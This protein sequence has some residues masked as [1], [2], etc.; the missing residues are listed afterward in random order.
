MKI[1]IANYGSADMRKYMKYNG[2]N[3][4]K[5]FQGVVQHTY[6]PKSIKYFPTTQQSVIQSLRQSIRESSVR[7]PFLLRKSTVRNGNKY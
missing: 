5:E 6:Q 3:V 2:F 1:V 7:R 4:E